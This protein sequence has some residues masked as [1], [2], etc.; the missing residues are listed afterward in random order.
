MKTPITLQDILI[1]AAKDT[2]QTL[3]Q[4]LDNQA[5]PS[6]R[7]SRRYGRMRRAVCRKH[8]R[9]LLPVFRG[10]LLVCI[11]ALFVLTCAMGFLRNLK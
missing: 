8:A 3:S 11:L 7:F 6:H 5:E 10:R 4:E 9:P 1:T 2:E